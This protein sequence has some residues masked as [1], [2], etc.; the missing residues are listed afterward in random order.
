MDIYDTA[1]MKAHP[2]FQINF[3][4]TNWVQ[5]IFFAAYAQYLSPNWLTRIQY[6]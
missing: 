4:F 2:A 6:W 1:F 5:M 3:T